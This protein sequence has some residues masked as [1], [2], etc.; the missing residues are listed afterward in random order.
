MMA[1]I[2]DWL[3]QQNR[4]LQ[5]LFALIAG[6]FTTLALPPVYM[7]PLLLI[8]W[9]VILVLV[10]GAQRWSQVLLLGW[11]FGA[12][13]MLA[14]LYWVGNALEI[15]GAPPQLAILLP[16]SMAFYPALALLA[17]WVLARWLRR[18]GV[19][20]SRDVA[21]VSLFS[22]LWLVAEFLRGYLFTGFPW[23]LMGYVWA[24]SD[25]MPQVA[26]VVGTYG[27]SLL[28]VFATAL[29]VCLFGTGGW[30]RRLVPVGLGAAILLVM[31]GYGYDRLN[32]AGETAY[33]DIRVRI[34]QANIS[35]R[36]KWRADL[37]ARNFEQHLVMSRKDEGDGFDLLVWPE[38]AVPYYLDEEP[39]KT[40]MMGRIV[41]PGGYVITGV[42]RREIRPDRSKRFYNSMVVVDDFGRVINTFDKFHLVPFGE[43]VP[44]KGV[45]EWL[46]VEKL[47]EGAGDFTPGAGAAVI[48]LA[49]MPSMSPLICYEV[50]F[51]GAVVAPGL[52]PGFL[53][54]VTNDA[55]YGETTGPYQ[56]LMITRFR[57][58]EGGLPMLRAAGTG[59]SAI[60]DAH[61]RVITQLGL[62]KSGTV[63][64]L[65]PVATVRPTLYGRHGNSIVWVLVLMVVVFGFLAGKLTQGRTE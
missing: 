26:S 28:T 45:L 50:I 38:T 55:W 7:V 14:G 61:G 27:L 24:F 35:Q 16:L 15:A 3:V 49:G 51:P 59:I 23:N 37:R 9:P 58:I 22:L 10:D 47:V 44:L 5:A 46:G 12:G 25:L 18:R 2:A 64:G 29:A 48:P 13:H 54:N 33:T 19:I 42:P 56:H 21:S 36:D 17:Y 65:L 40:V 63:D 11:L 20:A 52:R 60:I 39:A 57:A 32:E 31:G 41:R 4:W 53:L 62:G 6:L 43:Y 1:R 8:A 34:V 30:L